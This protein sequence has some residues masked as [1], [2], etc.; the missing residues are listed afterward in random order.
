MKK[1]YFPA[2]FTF[3]LL[4][5]AQFTLNA[6]ISRQAGAVQNNTLQYINGSIE[7]A[8][9]IKKSDIPAGHNINQIA[10]A[11][12]QSLKAFEFIPQNDG[13]VAQQSIEIPKSKPLS[14][15]AII[16]V[17]SNPDNYAIEYV[18]QKLPL[19]KPL[20]VE[21]VGNSLQ[22]LGLMTNA[23]LKNFP[24]AYLT[25]CDNTFECYSF[26]L[27]PIQIPK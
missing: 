2:V 9:Y 24:V 25:T 3:C 21:L 23:Q 10:V 19:M 8:V 17:K 22:N 4:F 6:Q 16:S 12:K 7:G 18:I 27:S 11:V 26:N 5:V 15:I 14:N 1:L 20:R 13:F